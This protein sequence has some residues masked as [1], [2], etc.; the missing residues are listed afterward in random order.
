[1]KRLTADRSRWKSFV[2]ALCSYT[3]DNRKWWWWYFTAH[4]YL[5]KV[6]TCSVIFPFTIVFAA[7]PQLRKYHHFHCIWDV[8]LYFST[9]WLN[10]RHV[11]IT[12]YKLVIAG[13]VDTLVA[14]LY[15][16]PSLLV[17]ALTLFQQKFPNHLTQ[18]RNSGAWSASELY[19][20]SDRRLSAKLVPTLADRG[21]RVVSATNPRRR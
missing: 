20:P 15:F 18:K 10:V 8:Q 3:G 16:L 12:S 7:M 14:R 9:V 21:C 11:P 1:V 13:E 6:L 17:L 4:M 5:I 19:R 2:E